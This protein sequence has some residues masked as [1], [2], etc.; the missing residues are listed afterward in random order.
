VITPVAARQEWRASSLASFDLVW[1]TVN[2]T[3]YDPQFEGIDWAGVRGELR[4]RVE[5][6][7]TPDA[8]RDVIRQMLARLRRSHFTLLSSSSADALPGTAVVPIDVRVVPEGVVVTRV[9]PGSAAERQG[10]KPGSILLGVDDSRA[11]SWTS[12][13]QSP[14]SPGSDDARARDLDVWR[15]VTR[16]LHGLS[17]STA[18]LRVRQPDGTTRTI[19]VARAEEPGDRVTLGNL[20]PLYVLAE[21]REVQTPGR[22]RAGVIAF[23]VWMTS[24]NTQVDDAIDRFRGHAGLVIDLRGNPGGLVAMISRVAGHLMSEPVVLGQMKTRTSTLELKVNPQLA[25]VDGRRVMPFAGPVAILVDELTASASECFAGALQGLGRARVFGRQT[26]VQALPASTRTLPNGDVLLYAL[27]DFVTASGRRI[28]G[29]GVMPD[30][31]QPLSIAALGA[32]RDQPLEAALRWID[33]QPLRTA[34]R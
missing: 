26:M 15:R 25:T 7:A 34:A 1:Q 3:F 24:V 4:P 17:D 33:A 18:R 2:D 21:S 27:G 11:A 20:R 14:G 23:N 12:A 30:E 16:V 28:E 29:D 10:L 6:A 22:R 31:T 13:P 32:G 8:A 5:A 19:E 9:A